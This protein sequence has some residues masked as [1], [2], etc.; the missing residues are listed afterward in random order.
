[1]YPSGASAVTLSRTGKGLHT[2]VYDDAPGHQLRAFFAPGG[3]GAVMRPDG[4]L[5]ACISASGG[6]LFGADGRIERRWAWNRCRPFQLD[7]S[8]VVTV[9]V[10]AAHDVALV[11]A[12]HQQPTFKIN[13]A[14]P[15]SKQ[16][17]LPPA[18]SG[19]ALAAEPSAVHDGLR[20]K[21]DFLLR[22][23]TEQLAQPSPDD[24]STSATPETTAAGYDT[25][26]F[27]F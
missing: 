25:F 13:M 22:Q 27:L 17:V 15:H 19:A 23:L 9:H 1:M 6:T 20:A 10:R 7:L 11:M 12:C 5:W 18:S 21:A 24:A 8:P 16:L 2:W 14:D 4:S 3:Q 26:G